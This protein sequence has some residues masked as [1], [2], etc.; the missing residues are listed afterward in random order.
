LFP[1]IV[2]CGRSV[3]DSLPKGLRTVFGGRVSVVQN[4]V[5]L[6][7]VDRCREAAE[8]EEP[9]TSERGLEVVSVGRLIPI[10][11][12]LSVLDGFADAAGPHDRLVFVGDGPLKRALF[13]EAWRAGLTGRVRFTGV[14]ERDEVYRILSRADLF[15]S[16]SRGEGLPLSVLEAMACK[17]P[18]IL[19]DIP[20]HSEIARLAPGVPLMRPG[21]I[22]A[23]SDAL[24]TYQAMSARSKSRLGARMRRCVEEHFSVRSMNDAYEM[25]YRER[26]VRPRRERSPRPEQ[27]RP[28]HTR[29]PDSELTLS[30][31]M[32]RH[33]P[34]VVALT[35]I[36]GC[37]GFWYAALQPPEYEAKSSVVVG[38]VFTGSPND[39]SVKASLALAA[40]Y[41]DLARREPVL[42][43][44]ADRLRLGDW[45]LLQ[46][47]VHSQ[48]GDKNPLLIQIT[49]TE[50]SS[51]QAEKLAEAVAT[52]LVKLTTSTAISPGREFAEREMDRLNVEI[53]RSE[54]RIDHLNE[55]LD[56]E[57][58]ADIAA[59][60]QGD[61][62]DLRSNLTVL[63]TS[64]QSMLDRFITAG[65]AGQV[66]VV[67]HAYAVPSPVRPDP[68]TLTLAGLVAGLM[69]AAGLLHVASGGRRP[70]VVD[71]SAPL[72]IH[73]GGG[74]PA[75]S[76]R[77]GDDQTQG[78]ATSSRNGDRR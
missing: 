12:P 44:V 72:Q 39:D 62:Q 23:L 52:E 14:V 36:G 1:T 51:V 31:R 30:G 21:D 56:T 3:R 49:A 16:T 29:P 24:T 77:W 76:D 17:C 43:P 2:T 4:G 63:Q 26:V 57:T 45:R 28:E 7:R 38:E 42:S 11:D 6:D 10:K 40:S 32:L 78:A 66:Q 71:Q 61:L 33:W 15:V 73:L 37:A 5:D 13:D 9:G 18:V 35:L 65:F 34:L 19:S 50:A 48:P 75:P 25:L 22:T 20:P 54:A 59:V 74:W 55:R 67:E 8:E 70:P 64:Y 41:A 58:D 53:D 60:L 27:T 68:V 69:L 46:T 47:K